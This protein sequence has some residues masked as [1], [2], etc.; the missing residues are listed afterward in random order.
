MPDSV[1]SGLF[2]DSHFVELLRRGFDGILRELVNRPKGM[3]LEVAAGLAPVGHR[4]LD[5][6]RYVLYRRCGSE[7]SS[8]PGGRFV[9]KLDVRGQ[10]YVDFDSAGGQQAVGGTRIVRNSGKSAR[11]RNRWPC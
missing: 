6:R 1:P 7:E 5:Q 10:G 4:E 2:E 3:V 11:Y 8:D 9:H